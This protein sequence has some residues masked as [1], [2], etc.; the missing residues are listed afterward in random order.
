MRSTSCWSAW[1][2][3]ACA[4]RLKGGA[5]LVFGRGDEEALALAGAGLP[6]QIVPG[7]SAANGCAAYAGIPLTHRGVARGARFVTVSG[8]DRDDV[9]FWRRLADERDVTLVFYMS[10]QT[11]GDLAGRLVG[12]GCPGRTPVAVVSQGTTAAQ[13]TVT[14]TLERIPGIADNAR[15]SPAL[16]IVG[17]TVAL[18]DRLAWFVGGA[19][20]AAFPLTA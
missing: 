3:T 11:L 13:R 4:S 1:S 18:R 2:A 9:S 19:D 5:P 20:A 17:E 7:V 10:G 8:R 6:F 14:G 12:A 16:V 15:L